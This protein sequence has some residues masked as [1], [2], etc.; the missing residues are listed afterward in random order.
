M[1]IDERAI[2]NFIVQKQG[3]RMWTGLF[4]L[5]IVFSVML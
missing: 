4:W 2:L 5:R 1:A 3:L